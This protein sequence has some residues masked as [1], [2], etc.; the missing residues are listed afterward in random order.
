MKFDAGSA[1]WLR[2]LCSYACFIFGSVIALFWGLRIDQADLNIP[3]AY[4]GDA[5][6]IL[7]LVKCMVETGTWWQNERLGAPG[8]Q[9]LYDFPII[10]SLH[11]G[12]IWLI[13]QVLPNYVWV[14]N[15]YH[16]L[17]Y[18][19]TVLTM[20]IVLRSLGVSFQAAGL[21]GMLFAFLP[22]HYIRG[23]GHYFLSVYWTL[24]LT[25]WPAIYLLSGRDLF[26]RDGRFRLFTRTGF[27]SIVIAALTSCSGAYYAFFGC[28]ALSFAGVYAAILSRN[29]RYLVSAGIVIV[30]I[31]IGG[32]VNHLPTIL[33]QSEHGPNSEVTKRQPEEAEMYG[34]KLA[35]MMLPTARHHWKFLADLRAKYDSD[36]RVLQ[37]E[38]ETSTL[39]TIGALS[40][41]ALIASLLLPRRTEVYHPFAAM[42]M[43]LVLFGTVGGS[44]SLFSFFVTA[45]VRSVNRVSIVIAFFVFA[46]LAITIDRITVTRR[47]HMRWFLCIALAIFGLWDQTS[48][49]WFRSREEQYRALRMEWQ[50][51]VS[52]M[53]HVPAWNDPGRIFCLPYIRY[54]ETYQ[55][56]ALSGYDHVRL[57]LHNPH[58]H[59]SFG[60]MSGRESDLW[61]RQ[62]SQLP[63]PEMIERL[64]YRDFDGIFLDQRGY[65]AAEAERLAKDL[66]RGSSSWRHQA[67]HEAGKQH[68][69][70]GIGEYRNA[71][72]ARYG[73]E[74]FER[75]RAVELERPSMLWLDGFVSFEPM[76]KEDNHRWC[77]RRGTA[78]IVNPSSRTRTVS[79]SMILRS[80][81]ERAGQ[82]MIEGGEIW[83]ETMALTNSS[84]PI[85]R[86][87]TVPPGRHVLRF[88][89][90]PHRDHVPNDARDNV[91]FVARFHLTEIAK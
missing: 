51:D 20:M 45:S 6:L 12:L 59:L 83:R 81:T 80:S 15:L 47:L 57:Y 2:C 31:V 23:L 72:I 58:M 41:L 88:R 17:S 69:F 1:S 54:P 25:L 71:M 55:C 63:V 76:G 61:A 56:E 4:H 85:E 78:I 91:F 32:L 66:S 70:L 24:P 60:A 84:P 87:W 48:R 90:E 7:P 33:Y 39:G 52:F 64:V 62:V 10:D 13:G 46:A 44:G 11:F 68:L 79:V 34:L 67:H 35:Q 28:L 22:Y 42:V 89:Y 49:D 26:F 14:F 75:R 9:E 82:L 40:L 27:G 77:G 18:P 53:S 16:L 43:F 74:E 5:L 21:A 19:L 37:N 8:N 50:S 86:V 38:N 65:P 30:V 29:W 73:L 3:L 36:H